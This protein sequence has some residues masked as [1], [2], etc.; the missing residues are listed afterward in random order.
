MDDHDTAFV[1]SVRAHAA[2]KALARRAGPQ[3]AWSGLGMIGIVGWSIVLPTLLGAFLGGFIE[4][5]SASPHTWTLALLV[6]GLM[7]GCV[8]AAMWISRQHAAIADSSTDSG[9][10]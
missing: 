7:L 8:N 10:A 2:R 4:R 9:D 5:H 1:R 3:A 6:A